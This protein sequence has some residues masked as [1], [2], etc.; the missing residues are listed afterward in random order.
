[1]SNYL[2]LF[3]II[4]LIFVPWKKGPALYLKVSP[5]IFYFMMYLNYVI[6]PLGNIGLSTYFTISPKYNLKVKP[7]ESWVIFFTVVCFSR[8]V[9]FFSSIKKLVMDDARIFL[10]TRKIQMEGALQ[11][12]IREN[13]VILTESR[14]DISTN[15]AILELTND[16]NS[17]LKRVRMYGEGEVRIG[18]SIYLHDDIYSIGFIAQLRDDIMKR[19]LDISTGK[20]IED[21][22]EHHPQEE[23][24]IVEEAT[25]EV[26]VDAFEEVVRQQQSL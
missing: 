21:S 24:P 18:R 11:S 19:Y 4:F 14:G 13:A 12:L 2:S 25:D 7:M 1:M 15:R 17:Y 5:Y 22:D 20:L 26:N 8:V 9:E 16:D 6:L 3:A 10:Q 23:E